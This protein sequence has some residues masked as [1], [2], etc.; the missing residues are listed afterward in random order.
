MAEAPEPVATFLAGCPPP[1]RAVAERL[2]QLV[3]STRP[4]A[5]ATLRARHNYFSYSLSGRL[6]DEI[7]SICPLPTYVR[8]DF[9]H[10]G[11]LSDP[12]RRLVGTGKRLRHIKLAT[13]KQADDP[14][15]ARLVRAAWEAAPSF[16]SK[17]VL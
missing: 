15:V 9:L 8:L 7:L 2:R 13:L 4:G 12:D 1:V 16:P 17:S 5:V 11:T 3:T 10:G 6:R 14:A